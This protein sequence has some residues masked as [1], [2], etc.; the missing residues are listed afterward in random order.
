M[1]EVTIRATLAKPVVREGVGVHTGAL[2]RVTLRPA[3]FGTGLR[4]LVN[5]SWVPV[6]PAHARA[7][8]GCSRL[9]AEGQLVLTPEH[10]LA[11]LHGLGVTDLEIEISGPEV[12]ILDG[13]AAEWVSGLD[14]AGRVWGP[15]L[16]TRELPRREVNAFGGRAR[17]GPGP[18]QLEVQ[19]DFGAGGPKGNY[20]VLRS[21]TAFRLEIAWA[22]T[23][24][25]ECD[26]EQFRAAGRGRGMTED[27]TVLWPR[28]SLRAPDEP[29]RHKLLDLWG[30]LA[31]LGP[32]RGWVLVERGSHA[33]HHA[34]VGTLVE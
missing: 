33:L 19:V 18:D 34:L 3:R 1:R 2:A 30:D 31:V 10:L 32:F 14:E 23:F 4:F 11:A 12:P 8:V 6:K 5:G 15:E 27:N 22:R 21:E 9:D 20:T 13:S 7:H 28:S 29:V 25:R 16:P 17:C 26:V 24:V